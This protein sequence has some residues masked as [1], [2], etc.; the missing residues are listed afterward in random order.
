M[1][2]TRSMTGFGRAERAIDATTVLTIEMSSVNH[3]GFDARLRVPDCLSSE[4]PAIVSRLRH[5]LGRG[6]VTLKCELVSLANREPAA[7]SPLVNRDYLVATWAT[8][9]PIVAN[10]D[11]PAAAA[12]ALLARAPEA[13]ASTPRSTAP[14]PA[15]AAQH[16]DLYRACER[17]AT[18]TLLGTQEDEGTA[19][20]AELEQLID[21]AAETRVQLGARAAGVPALQL[22]TLRKRAAD[23]LGS[24][25]P[26][27]PSPNGQ[28]LER[29]LALLAARGDVTEELARLDVHLEALRDT[30]H[31]GDFTKGRR[32]EFLCIELGREANTCASKLNDGGARS[33]CIDL[34]LIIERIREQVLNLA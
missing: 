7:P 23:L 22:E 4:Q 17:E 13:F 32:L 15:F 11:L 25:A 8:L 10:G 34:K 5:A 1:N 30:L 24:A 19:L 29:E 21:T 33:L 28:M 27:D 14:D 9:E 16:F 12:Y 2:A 3:R 6:S 20:A 26:G 31:G 18:A